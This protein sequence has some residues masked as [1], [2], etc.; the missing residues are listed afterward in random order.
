MTET[1]LKVATRRLLLAALMAFVVTTGAEA[2]AYRDTTLAPSVRARA[3]VKELTLDEKISLMMNAS[4]AIPRLG[5]RQYEWWNEAL[6]GVGRSGLATVFPQCIGMAASFDD[7][8][9]LKVFTAVSD[10]ARAKNNQY[11]LAGRTKR[12]QGLTFWTPNVNIFRD[13]RWGRGQETYGEDPYLTSVMGMAVVRGL[14]GPAGARHDKLHACAKHYAVH[15]GPEWSRHTF[16]AEQIAPRDL[17]ETYLPAFKALVQ[18]AGVQEVMCAY[19]RYEGDP[20]CGSNRLLQQILRDEWGYKGI[21][22]SDCG[23]INDIFIPGRHATEPDSAHAAS[24][25]VYAGTDLECGGSYASLRQAVAQG[26]VT[27]ERIDQ[28]V[29]RLLTARYA[30]GE[31]DGTTEWDALPLTV[32]DSREHRALALQ[33]ARESVVLLQNRNGLLP[34]SRNQKIALAGPNL[35]DSTMQWGNYNGHPSHTV[36]LG[37]AM[38]Q[39]LPVVATDA[40]ADVVVFAGGISPR[41]EGEEMRVSEPGFKG[42][43][44]TR[45]ELPEAQLQQLRELKAAG[46]RIVF[47]NFSGSALALPDVAELADAI[48]Q[49]WY[50]GQAGGEAVAQVLFGEY[51][52]AGRLPVTF[53][54]STDQLPD[55]EDYSMRGRTYRYMTEEPLYPFGYGLSYT[56]F[57]YGQ[58]TVSGETISTA[59]PVT[60]NIPVTNT[61]NRDGE[62]VVQLYVSRP[63]DTDGPQRTLRAFRRVAVAKGQTVTVSFTLTPETVEWFDTATNTVRPLPGDYDILFGGSSRLSDLHRLRLTCQPAQK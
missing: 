62:E 3:M 47:V 30:L 23:A 17:W 52:P 34:L 25:A 35:N 20:C 50:P 33:M 19:N 22:V 28:S 6:H 9:L 49:A 48:V 51:N 7:A 37:M 32:V 40:D 56:S 27:E 24:K 44:R 63:G 58:A 18:K 29:E 5:I 8:L 12:Y 13:P 31:M 38:S 39:R 43:D 14:Q 55:F 54:R 4:P 60:V 42:G 26:L 2:Q 36:T 15:S 57:R 21:V 53:Y 10:E 45:I 59:T 1:E 61:G 41:L 11:R 16:N 46:R